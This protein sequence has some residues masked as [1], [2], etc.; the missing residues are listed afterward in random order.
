MRKT[1]SI[2]KKAVVAPIFFLLLFAPSYGQTLNN[3]WE[4]ELAASLKQFMK[5]TN[6]GGTACNNYVGES[7]TKVYKVNDFYSSKLGRYMMVSEIEKYLAEEGKWTLLGHVYDQKT[8]TEAQ[9]SANSKKAVVALYTN[10]EG[11]GH[12]SLILPGELHTSGSWGLKVPNSASFFANQPENSYIGKGLSYAFGKN[13]I[14]D[15]VLYVRNY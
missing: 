5:C 12:I 11:I 9:Q 7:L 3:N 13:M 6:S 4:Q 1:H 10:D 14:K 2:I 15:V 8:L